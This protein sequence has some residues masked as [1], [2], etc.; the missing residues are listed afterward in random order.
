MQHFTIVSTH[1]P[2]PPSCPLAH[3]PIDNLLFNNW[4]LTWVRASLTRINPRSLGYLRGD[5]LLDKLGSL[6]SW[7]TDC[8]LGTGNLALVPVLC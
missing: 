3:P 6:V 8:E 5:G 4:P 7:G 1:L 2:P